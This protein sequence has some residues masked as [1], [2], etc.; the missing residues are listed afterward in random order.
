MKYSKINSVAR[1]E[2]SLT[3]KDKLSLNGNNTYMGGE[4]WGN[5]II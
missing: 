5:V 2:G 3:R 4:I 1:P